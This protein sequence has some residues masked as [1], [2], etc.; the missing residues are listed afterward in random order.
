MIP[1]LLVIAR[2]EWTA[3]IRLKWLRLLTASFSLLALAAAY[4]AGMAGELSGADGFARTS[5]A[6]VPVTLILVPLAGLI[7]G[8]TGQAAEA[9]GEPFLFSQPIARGTVV[10]ARWLG[11]CAALVGSIVGG[12]GLGGAIVAMQNGT[13]GLSGFLL[14]V[15]L[16]AILAVVFLSIAAAISATTGSRV[17]ALGV[18]VFAWFFF[19]L[20]YDGAALSGASWLSGARGGRILFGSIFGNP[21]DLVRVM[22][23]S[24]SGTPNVL[25]AAGDAWVRFLGGTLTAGAAAAGALLL[26]ATV[27]LMVAVRLIEMRDL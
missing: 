24:V 15:A 22:A 13:T 17:V 9:G 6:L 23:L 2:L 20:L 1:Q 19:V 18:A 4:S 8:V 12:L 27:P 16:T 5:M 3:A 21:V 10:L 14:F 26:W 25:G 11:Q 7:L